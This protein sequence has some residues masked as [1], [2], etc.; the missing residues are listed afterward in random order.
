WVSSF[1][2]ADLANIPFKQS[3]SISVKKG[4]TPNNWETNLA[5][6]LTGFYS[7]NLNEV[8]RLEVNLGQGANLEGFMVAG[9]YLNSLPAGS[10]LDK[11]TGIFYWQPGPGFYGNYRL[12]FIDTDAEGNQQRTMVTVSIGTAAGISKL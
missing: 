3:Q 10:T 5:A 12:V 7:I 11:E 8:E 1:A 2:T 4:A 9:E 6:G